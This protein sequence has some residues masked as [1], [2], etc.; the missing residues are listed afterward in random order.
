MANCKDAETIASAIDRLVAANKVVD[1]T[2]VKKWSELVTAT[3]QFE[4]T[5]IQ[6]KVLYSVVVKYKVVRSTAA[7]KDT[8]KITKIGRPTG[9]DIWYP[10]C[11]FNV[12]A[13]SEDLQDLSSKLK[14]ID[15]T[16]RAVG[17]IAC[18]PNCPSC[19]VTPLAQSDT[20]G[21]TLWNYNFNRDTCQ[22]LRETDTCSPRNKIFIPLSE[23]QLSDD[24]SLELESGQ[25]PENMWF[26]NP[27]F[28][29][30]FAAIFI[31]RDFSSNTNPS[32]DTSCSVGNSETLTSEDVSE[33]YLTSE[34]REWHTVS[35]ERY[36]YIAYAYTYTATFSLTGAIAFGCTQYNGHTPIRKDIL[37]AK[38]N[39]TQYLLLESIDDLLDPL[40]TP[41]I[42]IVPPK[43]ENISSICS[44]LDA[45]G[46]LPYVVKD[47]VIYAEQF[48][49]RTSNNSG[50]FSS[51]ID[52]IESIL[53]D[54]NS[55][56]VSVPGIALLRRGV[57]LSEATY[58]TQYQVEYGGTVC[59]ND[60]Q[61]F[62]D[63]CVPLPSECLEGLLN[64]RNKYSMF[65]S[66]PIYA[67]KISGLR[68]F[69]GRWSIAD[70][71]EID[72]SWD[73]NGGVLAISNLSA[74]CQDEDF[75]TKFDSAPIGI[76]ACRDTWWDT[77]A[78]T[79]KDML[80]ALDYG[81]SN[82]TVS[83][84]YSCEDEDPYCSQVDQAS[85]K[86]NVLLMSYSVIN[87]FTN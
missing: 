32:S 20:S 36:K 78:Y 38:T 30:K 12:I 24:T 63:S 57:L 71:S 21:E 80:C 83:V 17:A 77:E 65:S 55:H 67:V 64:I 35:G 16:E 73:S 86:N 56:S 6:I 50:S 42:D 34:E 28:F 9:T 47:P 62:Y 7:S 3:G 45:R 10:Q 87:P 46:S 53:K 60:F 33:E 54:E 11:Y 84:S 76:F 2:I 61:S 14:A 52:S 48:A 8:Y 69:S 72:G 18:F 58:E 26:P 1:S 49:K 15:D 43:F 23:C 66:L 4:N 82:G 13:G 81:D 70:Y 40:I 79:V 51:Y 74:A 22:K 27:V 68:I 31:P 19:T 59:E 44:S 85:I 5:T 37:G 39:I 25:N 75:S 41:T 29:P